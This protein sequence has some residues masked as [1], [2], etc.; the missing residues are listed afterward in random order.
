MAN[1]SGASTKFYSDTAFQKSNL[2][3]VTQHTKTVYLPALHTY[4]IFLHPTRPFHTD[5]H[6]WYQ[7]FFWTLFF[8]CEA[9]VS[10][11]EA[12]ISAATS[13]CSVSLLRLSL[14]DKLWDASYDRIVCDL[15]LNNW[16]DVL[17]RW[18]KQTLTA[19]PMSF[20]FSIK[21]LHS[22]AISSLNLS[23]S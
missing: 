12:A 6:V 18:E 10:F 2:S 3:L 1:A 21:Q 19:F 4:F 16:A 23:R 17:S 8:S 22:V 9:F 14:L 13:K 20:H 7:A 5:L 11:F 15:S